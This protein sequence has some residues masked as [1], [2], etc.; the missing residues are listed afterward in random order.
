VH[1]NG[2]C[3]FVFQNPDHQILMSFFFYFSKGLALYMNTEVFQ[4]PKLPEKIELYLSDSYRLKLLSLI[5]FPC[6][7]SVLET[8]FNSTL[9][10]YFHNAIC[11]FGWYYWFSPVKFILAIFNPGMENSNILLLFLLFDRLL[12]PQ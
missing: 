12:C 1:V 11:I 2:P 6:K 3:S 5:C 10:D 7:D 4:F 8:N 9:I